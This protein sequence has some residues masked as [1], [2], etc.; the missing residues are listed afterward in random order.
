MEGGGGV[1]STYR[2]VSVFMGRE[3]EVRYTT[4]ELERPT[5]VHMLGRHEQFEGPDV[6]GIRARAAGSEV[7][8]HAEF[9]F[10]GA[11]KAISPLVAAYLPFLARKPIQQLTRRLDP[12]DR[13]SGHE[14]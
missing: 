9:V 8:Y 13:N 2:N 5:R 11:A 6:L 12:L 3:T 10:S 4:V 14:G 1:G 7:S